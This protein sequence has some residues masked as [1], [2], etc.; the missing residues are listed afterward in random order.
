M[1]KESQRRSGKTPRKKAETWR[2]RV[3]P[4][5]RADA[6]DPAKHAP[7]GQIDL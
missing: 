4:L 6:L 2:N 3:A 7:D 5:F 1:N